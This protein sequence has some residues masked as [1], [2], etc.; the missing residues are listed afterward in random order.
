MYFR[1]SFARQVAEQHLKCYQH[2][3][4]ICM[5]DNDSAAHTASIFVASLY[6][7]FVWDSVQLSE[8]QS[9]ISGIKYWVNICLFI[10]ISQMYFST[11]C[12]T[13]TSMVM[14]WRADVKLKSLLLPPFL[15]IIHYTRSS[16]EAHTCSIPVIWI[17]YTLIKLFYCTKVRN[18]WQYKT[19][20]WWPFMINKKFV[21]GSKDVEYPAF[22]FKLSC[23]HC[24]SGGYK[25][26][27]STRTS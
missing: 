6:F 5:I 21:S 22:S 11:N 18:T 14:L 16:R 8:V 7:A 10:L 23:S 24:S 26:N 9:C 3:S 15:A 25:I 1:I 27:T 13:F 19:L 2:C 4:H 20:D 17:P 12:L